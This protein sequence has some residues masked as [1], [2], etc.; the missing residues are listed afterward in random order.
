[1]QQSIAIVSHSYIIQRGLTAIISDLSNASFIYFPNMPALN[2]YLE[3]KQPN[4]ILIDEKVLQANFDQ[5]LFARLNK[6]ARTGLITREDLPPK[7][8]RGIDFILKSNATKSEISPVFEKHFSDTKQSENKESSLLSEREKEVLTMVA[9]GR[10]NQEIADKLFISKHT[11]ISH[12]KNITAK[13]GIKTVSGL[14]VYAV[15]NKM[16]PRDQ[17]Q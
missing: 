3:E 5:D 15:L 16:I 7:N 14:T 13:L 9:Y 8:I 2:N 6:K 17:I 4:I 12:R 11:V 10:T 1:M